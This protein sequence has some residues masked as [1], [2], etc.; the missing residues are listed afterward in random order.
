MAATFRSIGGWLAA[1]VNVSW[2]SLQELICFDHAPK[3]FGRFGLHARV[4]WKAIWMPNFGQITIGLPHVVE[5]SVVV[6]F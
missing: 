2:M 4:V 6:K 3:L 1:P 5:T